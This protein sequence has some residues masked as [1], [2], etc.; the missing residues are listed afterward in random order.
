MSH[1]LLFPIIENINTV[2]EAY[3]GKKELQ[4]TVYLLQKKGLDLGYSYRFYFYGP[5]SDSLDEDIKRL[6]ILGELEIYQD[7]LTHR[8]RIP[9]HK[10][11]CSGS[12]DNTIHLIH[13]T[14]DELKDISPR[15]LELMATIVFLADDCI[16]T[17]EEI[18]KKVHAVKG[19]KYCDNEIR[20]HYEILKAKEYII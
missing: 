17:E 7:D 14:I 3:P 11:Y 8:I 12:N 10:E 20:E 6:S 18:I 19:D 5:Y 15:D 1:E 16:V 9:D 2:K 4:K 13:K